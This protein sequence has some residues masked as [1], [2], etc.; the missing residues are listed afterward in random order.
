MF[1]IETLYNTENY[2]QFWVFEHHCCQYNCQQGVAV[3]PYI[4]T[5]IMPLRSIVDIFLRVAVRPQM[6]VYFMGVLSLGPISLT[7]TVIYLM[8]IS[9]VKLGKTFIVQ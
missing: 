7:L 1:Y 2:W 4:P 6:G 3:K 8:E 9:L 5:N